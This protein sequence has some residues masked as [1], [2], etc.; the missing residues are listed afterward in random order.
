MLIK[1]FGLLLFAILFLWFI[2]HTII[3]VIDGLTDELERV[4]T[5]VVLGNKVELDGQPS[6]R[7]QARL[8]KSAALYKDEY[9]KYIIVSGGIGKEGFDEA[10]VMKQY[11]VDKGIP[12]EVII[13]DNDGYNSFM[14]AQNTT[15]IMKDLNL[16]SVMVITQYFHITRTKLA[17]S[18]FGHEDVYGA[19]AEI[20][21]FRDLYSIIREFPAYYKY[22]FQY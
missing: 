19:H 20:F 17:F 18:K 5:A 22:L 4:D 2:I 8:D 12:S 13:E 15:E 1:K 11:L 3:I 7:L 21:E 14:T 9:F 6:T 10:T 16:D